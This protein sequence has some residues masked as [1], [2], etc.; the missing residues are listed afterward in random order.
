ML[1]GTD[2][3][4]LTEMKREGLSV[5]AICELTGYD[6]KNVRK[7]LLKP[8]AA[9]RYAARP[10]QPHKLDGFTPYLQHPVRTCP[11]STPAADL[12]AVARDR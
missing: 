2:V 11:P 7:Y 1:R 10:E 8:E 3:N 5:Q 4:D 6:P 12:A 9:P